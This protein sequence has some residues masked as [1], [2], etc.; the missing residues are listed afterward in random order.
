MLQYL[1]NPEGYAALCRSSRKEYEDRLNWDSW[2][3]TVADLLDEQ[4]ARLR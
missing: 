4:V 1:E 2:G 3:Q